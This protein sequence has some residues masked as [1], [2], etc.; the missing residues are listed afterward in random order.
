MANGLGIIATNHA[1]IKDIL[2]S[3][4]NMLIDKNDINIEKIYLQLINDYTNKKS[5]C[6]QIIINRINTVTNFSEANYLF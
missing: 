5:L 4:K 1:G 3:E 6:E 2:I